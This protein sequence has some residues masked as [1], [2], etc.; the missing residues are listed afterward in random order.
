MIMLV[1]ERVMP[2]PVLVPFDWKDISEGR[3]RTG[4]FIYCNQAKPDD[5]ESSVEQSSDPVLR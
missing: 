5:R 2:W 1:S 3:V 4:G